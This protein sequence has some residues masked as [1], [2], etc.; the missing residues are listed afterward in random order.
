MY[1]VAGKQKSLKKK[2]TT[3]FNLE[4][5]IFRSIYDHLQLQVVQYVIWINNPMLYYLHV[6]MIVE[7]HRKSIKHVLL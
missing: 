7:P 5:D 4:Q 6:K 3:T 1:S 2:W